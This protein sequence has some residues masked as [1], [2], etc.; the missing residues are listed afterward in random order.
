MPQLAPGAS[1]LK[2]GLEAEEMMSWLLPVAILAAHAPSPAWPN[3]APTAAMHNA[4]GA[5]LIAEGRPRAATRQYEAALNMVAADPYGDEAWDASI[6]LALC[7]ATL[8]QKAPDAWANRLP[9]ARELAWQCLV[10]T[11]SDGRILDVIEG[12]G[13]KTA[14]VSFD[15]L[16]RLR[17]VIE[18]AS[19]D[20]QQRNQPALV[21]SWTAPSVC[22]GGETLVIAFAGADANLG[23]GA[24]GG[25]PSHEFVAS[26]RR[27]GVTRAIFVRD[28]LR[29]W[30]L[31]GVALDGPGHPRAHGEGGAVASVRS[32]DPMRDV[33]RSLRNLR[34]FDAMVAGL[35]AEIAAL[36]PARVVTI[37]SSMGGYAAVRAGLALDADAVVA[38]SPQVVIDPDE[39][40]R[41]QLPAAPFDSLLCTL[42][43]AS[44]LVDA[45]L[46]SL[47]EA[48]E[49]AARDGHSCAIDLHAGSAEV[50]D[51]YEAQLLSE[52]C[53]RAQQRAATAT[54]SGRAP[55][56][57]L[58][59]HE[60]RDH[61]LVTEMRNEGALDALLARVA[62]C[63]S[64]ASDGRVPPGQALAAAF[65]GFE[66]DADF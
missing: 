12:I 17:C 54:A 27:A 19:D 47:V 29:A 30:Y 35:Q 7:Y 44:E 26:C 38:F 41:M 56:C 49:A 22:A 62:G 42:K 9:T 1:S 2:E 61:N 57:K 18:A 50:G 16:Q 55:T 13:R 23:G 5:S 60:G 15:D 11:P 48:V 64:P 4:R 33:G 32:D 59:V 43:A 31:R 45:P 58:T 24:Q 36:R 65:V 51:V 40:A 34:S 3:S 20:H 52:A 53:E 28:A 8:A 46:T 37:G 6:N 25:V 10:S 14:P 39:R 66:G 21:R 63:E